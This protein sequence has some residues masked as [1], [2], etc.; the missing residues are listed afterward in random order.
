MSGLHRRDGVLWLEELSLEELGRHHGTPAYVYSRA[1]I[2]EH[3]RAFGE[4]LG[5]QAHL[6]CYSVKANSNLAVLRLL[7]ELGA[8]FDIVSGGELERV[9]AAGGDPG[10][11]VFSGIGKQAREM[12]RALEL[13]ILCFN[14]ESMPE[15]EL[16]STIA[17]RH[18]CSAPVAFR[19]NPGVDG[20]THPYIATGLKESKFGIPMS[21]ALEAYRQAIR[22]P[23]IEVVGLDCHIGSQ[24]TSLEP[25]LEALEALLELA[26][27]L[28]AEGVALRH[29]D[30]GG[31]LGVRYQNEAPPT[32]QELGRALGER[33]SDR[34]LRL[35]LE[36]GRSI[37]AAA[38][39]L[40][41][42]VQYLKTNDQGR[43][44]AIVDAAMTELLRPALYQAWMPVEP[45]R[46]RENPPPVPYDVVGPVCESA[47]FLAL[48][49]PLSLVDGDLLAVLNAGA[50][51]FVMS[52]NYNSR[53][54]PPEVMVDGDR[55]FLVRERERTEELM[56]GEALLPPRRR[57]PPEAAANDVPPDGAKTGRTEAGGTKTGGAGNRT[58]GPPHA[59]HRQERPAQESQE[60]DSGHSGQTRPP[61]E[62]PMSRPAADKSGAKPGGTA[63]PG[64]ASGA[65]A[66]P[67]LVAFSKMHGNGNDFAV[68][69][70]LTTQVELSAERIRQ[71]GDR[72][73]GIG[74]DQLLALL[75]PREPGDDFR[76]RV[77]NRDGGEAEQCGNGMR[78]VGRFVHERELAGHSPL[79]IEVGRRRVRVWGAARGTMKVDMGVPLTGQDAEQDGG[80]GQELPVPAEGSRQPPREAMRLPACP[81][82]LQPGGYWIELGGR[83]QWL[84]VLSIGNLHAVMEVDSLS[85]PELAQWAEAVTALPGFAAGVNVGFMMLTNRRKMELRVFERGSGETLSCGS[86]SCAA[87]VAG[88]LEGKLDTRVEVR[89][90]GGTVAVEWPDTEASVYLLGPACTVYEGELRW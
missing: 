28:R 77:F 12:E 64:P 40:L 85:R 39:L 30:L 4:G 74:Y 7:A 65:S 50:Y 47:D 83:R 26:D 37:I 87:M 70:L 57:R 45:V 5:N 66:D 6:I 11:V 34:G 81:E 25:F 33:L 48:N 41:T 46:Q 8:G 82:Q 75:P 49:R 63:A 13:G 44:F 61:Q 22:L 29:L 16:L 21:Q 23:A 35:L 68:L 84:R 90:R 15:L 32:A 3:Y 56:R 88:R 67:A 1:L 86:G 62:Q 71:L 89:Q 76:V 10:K 9:V 43:H 38:G 54:R 31:G 2:E 55:H 18:H 78:C 60:S 42:R 20:R 58:G 14:I 52:S 59:T 27:A 53:P 69:D 24:I 80:V 73:Q 79:T 19:V 72:Q 36:P 17:E 51:G